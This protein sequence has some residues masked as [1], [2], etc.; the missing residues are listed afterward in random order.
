MR[1]KLDKKPIILASAALAL[2]GA[3]TVGSAMAYF[4]TYS[5]ASGGVTM[6]MGFTKTKPNETVDA[7]GKH[8]TIENVG[9]YDC[10]VRVKVFSEFEKTRI[11]A[12]DKKWA[13]NENDQYWYYNDVLPAGASTP[14]LS[15]TYQFPQ[16]GENPDE[17]DRPEEL[18]IVVV[19]ECT[20]VL[21][22]ADGKP[23]AD[24]TNA[25]VTEGTN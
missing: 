9:D 19:Q 8:V 3:L 23:Y 11:G 16:A 14:E 7:N 5:T 25:F 12:K 15:V 22:D 20:P 21:Y 1:R 10:F 18:N 6:N 24:W 2:T 17:D 4:T 13:Y